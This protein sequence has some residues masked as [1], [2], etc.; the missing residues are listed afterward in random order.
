M[1]GHRRWSPAEGGLR[2]SRGVPGKEQP[3]GVCRK[4][5]AVGRAGVPETRASLQ[6]CLACSLLKV[7]CDGNGDQLFSSNWEAKG[8]RPC[9]VPRQGWRGKGRFLTRGKNAPYHVQRVSYNLAPHPWVTGTHQDWW[10]NSS[11]RKISICVLKKEMVKQQT[12]MPLG[13]GQWDINNFIF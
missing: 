7:A 2:Q 13:L 5:N 1:E 8:S 10:A 3:K 11:L 4:P 6:P 9:F 12:A